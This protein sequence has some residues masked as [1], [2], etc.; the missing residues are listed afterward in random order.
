MTLILRG[1]AVAIAVLALL[2]PVL[3]TRRPVPLPVEVLL[4]PESDPGHGLAVARLREIERELGHRVSTTSPEAPRARLYLGGPVP[5]TERSLPMFVLRSERPAGIVIARVRAA[6]PTAAG[7]AVAV[8]AVVRAERLR[9]RSSVIS[10]IDRGVVVERIE[11]TW[12]G[13]REERAVRLEY[14]APSAGLARLTLQVDTAGLDRVSADVGALVS[15]RRLRVL[16]FEPRPSWGAAFLRRALEGRQEFVVAALSRSAP[17]VFTRLSAGPASLQE[18]KAG[19]FDVLVVGAPEALTPPELDVLDRFASLR[20]GAVLLIPD[21]RLSGAVQQAFALPPM[22]ERL[23]DAPARIQAAGTVLQAS[24]LLVSRSAAAPDAIATVTLDG[25]SRAAVVAASRGE[26]TIVVSGLLDAWRYRSDAAER[27]WRGLIAD[28][29]V[30]SPDPLVV[31]VDPVLARTGD[32]VRVTARWRGDQITEAGGLRVPAIT[33]S[34]TDPA[35]HE[36][37]VRLWP[38]GRAGVYE[39]W[40]IAPTP[41]SYRIAAAG[42]GSQADTPLRVEWD[43]VHAV[44]SSGAAEAAAGRSGGSVVGSVAELEQQLARLPAVDVAGSTRPMR[45]PWWLVPF[46][47]CLCLEWVMRRKRGLR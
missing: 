37:I 5:F 1:I 47:G 38:G 7:Q 33:A 24:E 31:H 15:E 27:F 14:A 20:G 32:R 45:S 29:A 12:A 44:H 10:L 41:G 22:D 21:T 36:E 2:D 8:E 3:A 13:E 17:R 25:T 30:A 39:G 26:G 16:V 23:L 19:E 42:A 11:Q 34:I 43:V 6:R 18:L 4:P 46:A 35:G 9:G 40:I 28:L